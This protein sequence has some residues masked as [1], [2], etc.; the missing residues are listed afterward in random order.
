MA[1]QNNLFA[2]FDVSDTTAITNR[3]SST[4]LPFAILS[5][6]V[7]SNSWF[8]IT[9]SAITTKEVS[10]ALGITDGSNGSGIIVRVEN[11][12]GRANTSIWEWIVAKRGLVLDSAN[13]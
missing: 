6:P 4:N 3:L 2:L 13:E 8:L 11:Y 10:D 5:Q 1:T 7:S 9:L 12:F